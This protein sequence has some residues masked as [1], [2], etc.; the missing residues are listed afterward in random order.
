MVLQFTKNFA[1]IFVQF[2]AL[3]VI[4]VSTH[5]VFLRV[6]HHLLHFSTKTGT[7]KIN[8][9]RKFSEIK[10]QKTWCSFTSSE[11][12]TCFTALSSVSISS[13]ISFCDNVALRMPTMMQSCINSSLRV[14]SWQVSA[15]SYRLSMKSI[16]DLCSPWTR[17]LNRALSKITFVRKVCCKTSFY[18]L[19]D[20]IAFGKSKA[21]KDFVRISTHSIDQHVYLH[22]LVFFFRGQQQ[23]DSIQSIRSIVSTPP[24]SLN[25][26]F[27][28]EG[29]E[30]MPFWF[31]RLGFLSFP[32][33]SDTM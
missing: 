17:L 21:S 24:V 29:F 28:G 27:L 31:Y 30:M 7:R 2:S 23:W 11:D 32:D 16:T 5:V 3:I 33:T 15:S 8:G 26:I 13:C 1:L 19:V 14:P 22:F 6:W 20:L 4:I 10:D 25:L 9:G 18:S 12:F